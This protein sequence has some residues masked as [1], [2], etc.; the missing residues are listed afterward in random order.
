MNTEEDKVVDGVKFH[1]DGYRIY[2]IKDGKELGIVTEY[3]HSECGG[4]F[5]LFLSQASRS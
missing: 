3:K 5:H 1:D 4:L 2:A